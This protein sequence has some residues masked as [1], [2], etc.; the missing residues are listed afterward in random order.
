MPEKNILGL[1]SWLT[2]ISLIAGWQRTLMKSSCRFSFL[3]RLRRRR[4]RSS[5]LCVVAT[6]DA[7]PASVGSIDSR[8]SAM[9]CLCRSE[10]ATWKNIIKN[11]LLSIIESNIYII[12]SIMIWVQHYTTRFFFLFSKYVHTEQ[13]G[14]QVLRKAFLFLFPLGSIFPAARFEPGTA[15]CEARTLPLCYAVPP[16]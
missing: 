3:H 1:T 6:F 14:R 16:L 11:Y 4:R 7:T 5:S 13:L 2:S 9:V 15:G 8:C 12:I 10:I